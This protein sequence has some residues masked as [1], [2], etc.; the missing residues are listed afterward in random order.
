MP[1]SFSSTTAVI[2]AGG[3]GT[4]IRH[5]LPDLPKPMA[6]VSG[7][8]F[9]EWVVRYLKKQGLKRI[10]IST[11]FRGEKIE[12]YFAKNPVGATSICC[13]RENTPLGTAGGFLFATQESGL[14]PASWLV[15]NGDSLAFAT[16]NHLGQGLED[17]ATAGCILGVEMGDTSRFGAIRSEP[18]GRLT[19]FQEKL[20][21][22]GIIN[23]G[24]Y[25]F[26]SAT[27]SLFP[28]KSP[29]S[30]EH[31][32][33][34]ELLKRGVTLKVYA[35]KAPFLDIGTPGSLTQAE[36]FIRQNLQ[37]FDQT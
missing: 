26:R 9:L 37:E 24:M 8:P 7:K 25:L 13:V 1:T 10:V 3:L 27:L 12:E 5:L 29:L 34:P 17:P 14:N 4:R 36:L 28:K 30:F 20:P 16:L 6:P 19:G 2:L 15:L 23:A 22:A 21:G 32:V 35:T 18:D 31:D 33:F 11:G